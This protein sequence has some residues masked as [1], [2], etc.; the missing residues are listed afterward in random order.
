MDLKMPSA[1]SAILSRPRCGILIRQ[2]GFHPVLLGP[3]DSFHEVAYHYND[4][5][6]NALAS[7]ITSLTI[8]YSP[9]Y[10]DA[11]QRKHKAPRH[12]PLCGEFTGNSPHKRPVTRKMFPFDDVIMVWTGTSWRH[13]WHQ[14]FTKVLWPHNWNLMI[15]LF[16]LIFFYSNDPIKAQ[17]CT[18]HDSSAVVACAKLWLCSDQ[19]KGCMYFYNICIMGSLTACEMS[20]RR[21]FSRVI[22]G[23]FLNFKKR[24]FS[25]N[26]YRNFTLVHCL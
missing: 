21:I 22:L 25:T 8:V 11:D 14:L 18:C 10:L 19:C 9:A 12:W 13:R 2:P 5:I 15:I 23:H 4:V 26:Y 16:A 3:W 1:I 24:G 6:M 20:P 17:F 7:Q